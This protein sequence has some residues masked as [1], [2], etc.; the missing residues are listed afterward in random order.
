MQNVAFVPPNDDS[1]GA[2]NWVLTD[3]SSTCL[4]ASNDTYLA[5][6]ASNGS[7]N[8]S[9]GTFPPELFAKLNPGELKMYNDY[10][11]FVKSR[12]GVEID[13]NVITSQTNPKTGETYVLKCYYVTDDE[14]DAK[15]LPPLPY[16]PVRAR[17]TLDLWSFGQVLFTMC[18]SGHPLFPMNVKTGHLLAFDQVANWSDA[19]AKDLI[20]QHIDDPLAQ[21]LLFHIMTGFDE[22]ASLQVETLLSHPFF[23]SS[24]KDDQLA[25]MTQRMIDQRSTETRMYKRNREAERKQQAE[26]E[27]LTTRSRN[28]VCWDLDFQMR[29]YLSPSNL[30]RKD[31]PAGVVVPEIPVSILLLPYK[32]AR[33]KSGKLTPSTKKDVERAERMGIQLL[34]LSRACQF[35]RLMEQVVVESNGNKD[36]SWSSSEIS[37]AI[38]SSSDAF[39]DLENAMTALAT[40]EIE[41]FRHNPMHVAIRLVQDRIKELYA[42]FDAESK[43]FLYLVDEFEGVPIIDSNSP[44]PHQVVA[45][46][47]QVLQN[48]LPLMQLCALYARG[49]CGGVEGLVKLIFEAAYPHI[50]PSWEAAAAGLRHDMDEAAMKTELRILRSALAEL[51]GSKIS[52]VVDDLRFLQTY[53]HQFDPHHSYALL[54]RVTNAE[55]CLWTSE[56]GVEK[57]NELASSSTIVKAHEK[58]KAL[59]SKVSGQEERINALEEELETL[60]F[61]L[62]HNLTTP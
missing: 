35:A 2:G 44:Y 14:K 29:V 36:H 39:K 16:K 26:V 54:Q 58:Q 10:W 3:L 32:L 4:Q 21:D 50:P 62:K 33:N 43:A 42:C 40:S 61:R 48:T 12:F 38:A 1:D 45:K 13:P 25:K 60:K 22:R 23:S 11:E 52:S 47:P 41:L 5:G 46:V 27:W 30:V 7:A 51:Y 24:D 18:S 49:V 17:E 55:S 59:E 9:T 8:F 37:S 53:L 19:I 28:L 56:V 6:I 57:I 34:A 31:H 20:Y 15:K